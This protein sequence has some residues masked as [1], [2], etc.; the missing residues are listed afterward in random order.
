MEVSR[1]KDYTIYNIVEI[2]AMKY[3]VHAFMH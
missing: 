1:L 3:V 2:K